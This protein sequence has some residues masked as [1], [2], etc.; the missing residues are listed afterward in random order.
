MKAVAQPWLPDVKVEKI[1]RNRKDPQPKFSRFHPIKRYE[2]LHRPFDLKFRGRIN[3]WLEKLDKKGIKVY[4]YL[5]RKN[6]RIVKTYFFPQGEKRVWLTQ[7]QVAD[8][9]RG[10]LPYKIR[11]NIVKSLIE[12][13]EESK[14]KV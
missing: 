3:R 9:V 11:E 4:E 6:Y 12:I 10:I 7:K 13:W 14:D 2:I 1:K 5:D 8:T